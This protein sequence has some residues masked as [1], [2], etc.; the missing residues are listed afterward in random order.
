MIQSEKSVKTLAT[1]A[2]SKSPHNEIVALE[3][4]TKT[5]SRAI[6]LDEVSLSVSAGE[7]VVLLG[8]SG[9]GKSTLLRTI[10]QL[11]KPDSGSITVNGVKSDN[12]SRTDLRKLRTQVGFIFQ[13]FGLVPSASALENVLMG[14][15]GILRFPRIGSFSYP[16]ILRKKA[17]TLLNRVGLSDQIVQKT[18]DLSGGQMQ[19]VAVARSLMLDP[20][21]ILADEPISS[22]DP[23][24]SVEVMDLL[25]RV[26]GQGVTIIVSLHQVDYALK[27]ADRVIALKNGSVFFDKPTTELT[28]TEISKIYKE[29]DA[30]A[31]I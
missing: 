15:L 24:T 1:H 20:K 19:R 21:L 11:V 4:V 2:A 14:S 27:Y 30:S 18:S 28:K 22:L 31:L 6:A 8:R 3:N 29:V 25:K 12:L 13:N 26:N 10:I 7:F 23:A 16:S 17:I 9:S 5:F